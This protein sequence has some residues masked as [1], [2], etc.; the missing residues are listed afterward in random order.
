ARDPKPAYADFPRLPV[1][2]VP[3]EFVADE[4]KARG[5]RPPL[6]ANDLR[7]YVTEQISYAVVGRDTVG[8]VF[9]LFFLA[10]TVAAAALGRK[11]LL[12][13]LGWLGPALA[14]GAAGVFF[15]L[16]RWSR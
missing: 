1:A 11:R 16:G 9:G 4:F 5:E 6:A 12:E 14:L 2:L 13:H 7:A 8:L 15:G 10:L 3:F